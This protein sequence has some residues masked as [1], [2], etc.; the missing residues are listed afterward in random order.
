MSEN[1]NVNVNQLRDA[2][3]IARETLLAERQPGG[4]WPGRLCSSALASAT[5]VSA[6]SVANRERFD[7]LIT[8][9]VRWLVRTQ[10]DN[11]GWGDTADS[12]SNVP[13]TML[14]RAALKLSNMDETHS[15]CTQ[16]AEDYLSINA[17]SS[18]IER[19][20]TLRNSYGDDRTFAVPILA[21]CA[22]AGMIDWKQVPRLPF[23]LAWL[24]T[25][26]LHMLRLHV[27]SYATPALIAIGQLLHRHRPTRNPLLLA[28]RRAAVKPTLRKLTSIQPASGGFIE[29]IPLTSFVVMGLVGAGLSEH[30]VVR[31]GIEFITKSA[32]PDGS[33]PIDSNLATWVTTQALEALAATGDLGDVGNLAETK[34]WLLDQQ[35]DRRHPYTGSPPGGWGW[36]PLSGGVPDADDTAGALLALAQLESDVP[37]ASITASITAGLKWLANLQNDDGG[38]PTFC[39]GWRKLPFDRSGPD[40]TAHAIRAFHAWPDVIEPAKRERALRAGFKY[41]RE[42]QRPDG[43]WVPLWFGSQHTADRTNPVYGTARVLKAYMAADP[44]NLNTPEAERGLSFLADLQND[45]GGWGGGAGAPSSIEETALAVEALAETRTDGPYWS[46]VLRGARFLSQRIAN[47]ALAESTPIGLYFA[48]LWYRQRLYPVIWSVGALGAVLA[49]TSKG[50]RK[51]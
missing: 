3:R 25:S 32:R 13:T 34:K 36:T 19:V 5:A 46:N 26:T 12:P 41:L 42:T 21:N 35:H 6:L 37:T 49:K 27:V 2:Y 43:S 29:A 23:E 1:A 51:R 28:L 10:N 20:R 22:L 48:R 15:T 31:A 4:F 45:D 11:G 38:W 24:P 33:W 7:E 9:G 30:P 47:G 16:A 17:G 39:R 44:E 8:A 50:T 14:V 18:V 40:L